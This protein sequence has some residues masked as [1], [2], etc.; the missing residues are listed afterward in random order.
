[1]EETILNL[2]HTLKKIDIMRNEY[3]KALNW[4]EAEIITPTPIKGYSLEEKKEKLLELK[5]KTKLAISDLKK[6][7]EEL[8]SKIKQINPAMFETA[9]ILK[10]CCF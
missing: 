8:T 2:A 5:E 7:E 9:K 10:L 1:M 4:V 3:L 6:H